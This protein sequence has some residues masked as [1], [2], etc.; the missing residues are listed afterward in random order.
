MIMIKLKLK[1]TEREK[2]KAQGLCG[3]IGSPQR[4]LTY[5]RQ[6]I[7]AYTHART[8]APKTITKSLFTCYSL[9]KVNDRK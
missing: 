7:K 5:A 3:A 9:R 6:K 2:I 4:P 1:L 8:H